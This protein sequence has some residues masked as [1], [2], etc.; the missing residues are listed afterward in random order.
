MINGV[1]TAVVLHGQPQLSM[2]PLSIGNLENI[3]VMRGAGPVCY[4]PQNVDG[5]INFVIRMIPEK[6]S[7]EIGVT[8]EHVSHGGWKKL[9]QASLDE[10]VGNGLGVTPLYSGVK[11]ADCHDSD[12]SNGIDDM[13]L[14]T[15]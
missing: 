1:L 11:G 13:L 15:H 2:M 8:I 9:D 7:G 4:G 5:V 14:K 10:T 12:N 6:F 3:G